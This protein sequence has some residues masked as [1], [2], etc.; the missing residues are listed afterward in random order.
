MCMRAGPLSHQANRQVPWLTNTGL[1]SHSYWPSGSPASGDASLTKATRS[2]PLARSAIAR[3]AGWI[4]SPSAISSATIL[5]EEENCPGYTWLSM[6]HW[7][8]R[9]ECMGAVIQ[10]Q[11]HSVFHILEACI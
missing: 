4:C 3:T 7:A 11:F 2:S 9:V 8:H 6:V 10:P 1:C 5:I